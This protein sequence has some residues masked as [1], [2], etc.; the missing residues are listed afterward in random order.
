[1]LF[2]NG[3]RIYFSFMTHM[4]KGMCACVRECTCVRGYVCKRTRKRHVIGPDIPYCHSIG[5]VYIVIPIN[6]L[7]SS[8][9]LVVQLL[10]CFNVPPG[11]SRKLG[12]E[13]VEDHV[14]GSHHTLKKF[15]KGGGEPDPRWR[16]CPL[17][18]PPPPQNNNKHNK[19]QQL[20]LCCFCSLSLRVLQLSTPQ[21]RR[22]HNGSPAKHGRPDR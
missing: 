19:N 17:P 12:I 9:F 13:R 15:P 1:M 5:L 11:L 3:D 16:Q 21:Q 10:R 2:F 14:W 20:C 4:C 8:S 7:T 22:S 6:K 18:L